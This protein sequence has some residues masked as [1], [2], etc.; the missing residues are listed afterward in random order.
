MPKLLTHLSKDERIEHDKITRQRASTKYYRLNKKEHNHQS[1][2]NKFYKE[3]GKEFI[4]A[5][6]LH[7]DGFDNML[8]E[9]RIAKI[10]K[11]IEGLKKQ[12]GFNL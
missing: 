4:K 9:I 6:I 12:I 8:V 5:V 3:Y 10:R 11:D 7:F 1:R 2:L